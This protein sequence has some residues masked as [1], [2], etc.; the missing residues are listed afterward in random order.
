[1]QAARKQA[2]HALQTQSPAATH[3][4]AAER[5]RLDGSHAQPCCSHQRFA[6]QLAASQLLHRRRRRQLLLLLLLPLLWLV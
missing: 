3:L 6:L 5:H 2:P 4:Q 1:M